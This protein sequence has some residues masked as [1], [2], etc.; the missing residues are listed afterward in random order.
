MVYI[1]TL[2]NIAAIA[3]YTLESNWAALAWC[4]VA[5][6]SMWAGEFHVINYKKLQKLV[7]EQDKTIK[8]LIK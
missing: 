4:V 2:F 6:L 7:S 5:T 1:V 8:E 3:V